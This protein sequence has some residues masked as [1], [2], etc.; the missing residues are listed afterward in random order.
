MRGQ[1]IEHPIAITN[2]ATGNNRISK[3]IFCS[4]IVLGR[5]EGKHRVIATAAGH[6]PAGEATCHLL[7]IGFAKTAPYAQ[8]MQ[9]HQLSGVIFIRAALCVSNI[10][11]VIKHGKAAGASF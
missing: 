9:F 2:A 1:N 5:R 8:G 4:G 6:C 11:Q 10:V 3:Y 7:D